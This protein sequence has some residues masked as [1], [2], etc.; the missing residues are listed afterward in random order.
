MSGPDDPR[1]VDGGFAGETTGR[2]VLAGGFWKLA[3]SLL[4]QLYVVVV[5][6]VAAR[7]LGPLGMGQQSY[8][9]FVQLT[10]TLLITGGFSASLMRYV[11]ELT[12]RREGHQVAG[13]V[14]WTWRRQAVA[15]AIGAGA[16]AAVT[17]P[18]ADLAAA[19]ALAS[20]A[21]FFGVVQ[22]VPHAALV[23]L[24]RWRTVSLVSLAIGAVSTGVAIA[25]LLAG[26]GITGLFAVEAVAAAASFAIFAIVIRRRLPR[27]S[28]AVN[29]PRLLRTV[30]RYASAEWL[31]LVLYVVVW[32]RS[33]LFVLERTA[34]AAEIAHYSIAFALVTT[35]LRVPSALSSTLT[36][37]FATLVGQ[38]AFDRITSGFGRAVRMLTALVLPL[39]AL[40]VALS[41]R[42]VT[43][44]YGHDYARAGEVAALMALAM[45]FALLHA[46]SSALLGGIAS[47]RPVLVCN[48]VATVVD[49]GLAIWL[50]PRFG[51]VGAAA[52]NVAAQV[53]AAALLF[54]CARRR[55]GAPLGTRSLVAPAAC[56][57]AA[58]LAA[59]GVLSLMEGVGG[60][61][62]AAAAGAAACALPAF[63]FGVLGDDDLGW[64]A[65]AL[66]GRLPG[67]MA[68]WL[69]LLQRGRPL[70]RQGRAGG[71]RS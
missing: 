13:L 5:S 59:W 56:A 10:V 57:A 42:I 11:A 64:L 47:I 38:G 46:T 24:Q 61:A 1:A 16:L 8:I 31:H 55:L 53:S 37:A 7:V 68:R 29:D 27:S 54:A 44:F 43:V 3:A 6:L 19:W 65:G 48:G 62:L 51:A 30:R 23:G 63:T 35:V 36:P 26:G 49:I 50:I 67:P 21:A 12:G 60:L 17:V 15:A 39:T 9:S 28:S 58:G 70:R 69:R 20:V 18:R 2:S 66:A 32:R 4:P 40:L 41:P 33:E 14:A 71:T 45:P 25:V 34:G 52:A 22:S